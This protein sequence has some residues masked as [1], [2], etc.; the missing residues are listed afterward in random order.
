Y[1]ALPQLMSCAYATNEAPRRVRTATG[2]RPDVV[3]LAL[4]WGHFSQP[5]GRDCCPGAGRLGDRPRAHEWPPG[6]LAQAGQFTT[7]RA[8]SSQPR[9]TLRRR[10]AH[11]D[12]ACCGTTSGGAAGGGA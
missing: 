1:T 12:E 4:S 11:L 7:P 3:R 6:V 2:R 8:N 5:G 9:E 10:S